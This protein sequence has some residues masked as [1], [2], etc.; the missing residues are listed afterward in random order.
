MTSHSDLERAVEAVMKRA[1]Q[2]EP[3]Y[4]ERLN[5]LRAHKSQLL[6]AKRK[7]LSVRQ[8]HA[9][10]SKKVAYRITYRHVLI[11]IREAENGDG[12]DGVKNGRTKTPRA[13]VALNDPDKEK[14]SRSRRIS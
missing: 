14:N 1:S 2:L 6:N 12:V 8:I 4:T 7:G 9:E 3:S 13:G 10:L 11:V 5:A